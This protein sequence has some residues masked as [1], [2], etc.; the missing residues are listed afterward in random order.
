MKLLWPWPLNLSSISREYAKQQTNARLSSLFRQVLLFL[1][2]TIQNVNR[3][4]SHSQAGGIYKSNDVVLAASAFLLIKS[5]YTYVLPL[6]NEFC[7]IIVSAP[8]FIQ[9]KKSRPG[10][11][12]QVSCYLSMGDLLQ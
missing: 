3:P 11:K 5:I 9:C 1:R 2:T 8:Y 4:L 10:I 7:I 12:G 6:H